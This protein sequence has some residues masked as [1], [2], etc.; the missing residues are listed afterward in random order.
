MFISIFFSLLKLIK[1]VLKNVWP[2]ALRFFKK[3]TGTQ[4]MLSEAKKELN[5]FLNAWLKNM[6]NYNI[7]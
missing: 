7:S 6:L 3:C 1:N 5:E 2:P 4:E